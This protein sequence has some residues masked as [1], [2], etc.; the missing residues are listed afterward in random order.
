MGNSLTC[1]HLAALRRHRPS[2]AFSDLLHNFLASPAHQSDVDVVLR[3]IAQ[4]LA[5]SLGNSELIG[6]I[7]VWSQE[8]FDAGK[9]LISAMADGTPD[10][11]F[12]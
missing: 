6:H 7:T 5:R 8:Y 3:E 4:G 9:G 11:C 12:T 10:A 1:D 2:I